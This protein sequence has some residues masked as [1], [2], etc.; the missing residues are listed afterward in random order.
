MGDVCGREE[1]GKE[2]EGPQQKMTNLPL[3]NRLRF[4]QIQVVEGCETKQWN[5]TAVFRSRDGQSPKTL[6]C[7]SSFNES[8]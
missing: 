7:R 4:T 6:P 3:T 8:T 5:E 1:R 2:G